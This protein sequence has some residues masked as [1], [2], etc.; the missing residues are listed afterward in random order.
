MI[1]IVPNIPTNKVQMAAKIIKALGRGIDKARGTGEDMGYRK[2]KS[3]LCPFGF[4][5]H[6]YLPER[7]K[8]PIGSMRKSWG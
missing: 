7:Y 8:N 1:V 3:R 2:R 5:L 4:L 6:A